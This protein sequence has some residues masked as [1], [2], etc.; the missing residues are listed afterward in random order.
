WMLDHQIGLDAG[1]CMNNDPMDPLGLQMASSRYAPTMPM[2]MDMGKGDT[3]E[4]ED[5]ESD[6]RDT[7]IDDNTD[8]SALV[9]KYTRRMAR[10]QPRQ[11]FYTIIP[12]LIPRGWYDRPSLWCIGILLSCCV[13]FIVTYT[14]LYFAD[15]KDLDI[16]AV[17]MFASA[18]VC[19][20]LVVIVLGI[21]SS[22]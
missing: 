14:S 5:S 8:I 13:T 15:V 11:P 3:N 4:E 20:G 1:Q 9:R 21:A 22:Y 18:L 16:I 7:F 19:M 6:G 12:A 17:A 10:Q 2:S